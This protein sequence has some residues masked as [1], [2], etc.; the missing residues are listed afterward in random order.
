MGGHCESQ[1][2]HEQIDYHHF[3]G[4]V[5]NYDHPRHLQLLYQ[6]QEA[7]VLGKSANSLD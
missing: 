3:I 2:V 4:P 6:V 7:T 1:R 5:P